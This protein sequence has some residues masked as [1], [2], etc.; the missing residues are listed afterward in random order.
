MI[1]VMHWSRSK[2]ALILVL[3]L[4]ATIL[5]FFFQKCCV[6]DRDISSEALISAVVITESPDCGLKQQTQPIPISIKK[7]RQFESSENPSRSLKRASTLL[8]KAADA[9]E[10]NEVVAVQLIRQVIAILKFQVIPSLLES[11]TARVSHDSRS[12]LAELVIDG[13]KP[14]SP[15]NESGGRFLAGTKG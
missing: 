6:P 10:T 1:S 2:R 7:K 9:L 4:L 13:N 11:N 5:W 15:V 12:D 3:A 8:L 14:S